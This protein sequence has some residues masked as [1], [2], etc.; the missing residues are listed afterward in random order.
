MSLDEELDSALRAMEAGF[1]VRLIATFEPALEWAPAEASAA[2]WLT[3]NHPNFDQF[4]V[5]RDG[6]AVGL[7]FRNGNH[8]GQ[9]VAEAM[10]PLR[11]GLIVSSDTPI[12]DLI[13]E[14]RHSHS[15]LVL[16]GGRITGLVT[17][18]DLLKLPVRMLLFGLVTHLEICLR[19]LIKR[20]IPNWMQTLDGKRRRQIRKEFRRAS[21]ARLDP[22]LL[23]FT[24]FSDLVDILN[25][26]GTLGTQFES[27][28]KS[29]RELRNLVAHAATYVHAPADVV[30]LAD[31]FDSTRTWIEGMVRTGH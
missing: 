1:H 8:N 29:I 24:N 26:D 17:Q 3:A 13:P 31:C 9:T 4:P 12:S 27:D 15:R 11:D 10:H 5:R 21:A 7:L 30:R 23:E 2:A 14:L 16:R 6:V 25:R 18:S 22:D 20:R 19:A 28:M